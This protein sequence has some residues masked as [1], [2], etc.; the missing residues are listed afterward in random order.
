MLRAGRSCL[1]TIVLLGLIFCTSKSHGWGITRGIAGE[2]GGIS[3]PDSYV[4]P[5]DPTEVADLGHGYDLL[6][7]RRLL[8]KCVDTTNV[9]RQSIEQQ[10][11]SFSQV[12]DDESLWRRLNTSIKARASYAGFS[13][14][15]SFSSELETKTS[16]K[17]LSAV[18]HGD[19]VGYVTYLDT[20]TV[21]I[22]S[23]PSEPLPGY[24]VDLTSNSLKLLKKNP[25][26]FREVCGDAF[27]QQISWGGDIYGIV[28]YSNLTFEERQRISVA[29]DVSGPGDIFSVN[30][31]SDN[32]KK[33][34]S[35]KDKTKIIYKREV[36]PQI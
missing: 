25:A 2:N 14:G 30:G 6:T 15:G 29:L 13:G 22:S 9:K 16:S 27:V 32:E 17:K 3:Q 12:V 31:T 7:G 19:F 20:P 35:V 10:G 1:N 18:V 5:F 24:R 33:F 11:G 21:P 26:E 23:P 28:E 36:A 4:V 8:T 34:I